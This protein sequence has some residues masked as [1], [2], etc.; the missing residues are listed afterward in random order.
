MTPP[1]TRRDFVRD[2]ALLAGG[3]F[4]FSRAAPVF[5]REPLGFAEYRRH[6]AVGLAALVRK[7]DASPGEL[8]E[9]AIARTED[10][11]PTLNAVVTRHYELARE[12][13][14]RGLPDGPLRGVPYLLKDLGIALAGTVTTQGSVFF[15][16]AVYDYDSTL[17]TRYRSAGLVIFGKTHS[18]ELGGTATTESQLFGDTHNPWNPERS[19][20]GSSGGSAAAVAAGIVP[21]AHASDGGG[22]IRI[23]ASA[24][25]LFGLKPTR[26]RVP[27][28]PTVYETRNGLAA[29]HAV[30][31][32]VRDSAALLDLSQGPAPGDAYAAP[33]RARPYLEEVRRPPGALRIA[34]MTQPL[35]PIPVAPECVAAAEGAARLCES[36]GHRVELARPDLDGAALFEALG[37]SSNV[38]V[39]EIVGER[40]AALGRSVEPEELEPITRRGLKAGRAARAVDY[41]RARKTLHRASRAMAGF[42]RDRDV[43]LS[44]TMALVPPPL[45][46]LSLRREFEDF[47]GVAAAA[48][49][50]TAV[51]N[52]T[53]QPAMSVPLHW[54]Q[55][56]IPVGVMFAGRFGDE[57]T[58]FRLAAQLEQASPWFDRVPELPPRAAAGPAFREIA[59]R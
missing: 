14:A 2:A 8:L 17:V 39:A 52:M 1:L 26:G 7:G 19:A 45:G 6:D 22:S 41:A 59:W 25:G 32:S 50:F 57:A 40:E 34:L 3:S 51:Y 43:I 31:R 13:V 23:P 33:P 46:A 18:P 36:L 11:N 53:G 9:I 55:D 37:I 28:G 12:A 47:M 20:G 56:G 24:C 58:L 49:V 48:S 44:P 15:R 38:V 21:A 42:L 4:A 54:T 10:V 29:M 35:L 16:D 5:A 27:M 30:S